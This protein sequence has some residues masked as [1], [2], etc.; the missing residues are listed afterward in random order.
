M[1]CATNIIERRKYARTMGIPE[2]L[3]MANAMGF[4][5]ALKARKDFVMSHPKKIEI[6]RKILDARSNKKCI[7]FSN[8]NCKTPRGG[9]FNIIQVTVF[10]ISTI[11]MM[12]LVYKLLCKTELTSVTII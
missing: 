1:S 10:I 4:M 2:K 11:M 9:H 8:C 12:R 6:A 3:V 5:K 7:T